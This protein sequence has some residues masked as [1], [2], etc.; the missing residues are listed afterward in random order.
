MT[1]GR[2]PPRVSNPSSGSLGTHHAS[3]THPRGEDAKVDVLGIL[4]REILLQNFHR[5][6]GLLLER[7]LAPTSL[8]SR[9]NITRPREP[10]CRRR[11]RSGFA[12]NGRTRRKGGGDER[13]H[14]TLAQKES[15][16]AAAAAAE[17]EEA[18]RRHAVI[19]RGDLMVT[20]LLCCALYSSCSASCWREHP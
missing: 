6:L 17:N 13:V 16:R 4:L 18:A 3:E 10:H 1:C 12:P 20:T 2:Q 9:G 5:L 7:H 11:S 8:H 15:D 14:P 19:W